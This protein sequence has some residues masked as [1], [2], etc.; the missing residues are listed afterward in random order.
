MFVD[1]VVG[2]LHRARID[3]YRIERHFAH[4]F[5]DDAVVHRFCRIASPRK[6]AVSADEYHI[7]FGRIVAVLFKMLD[8]QRT[9]LFFVIAFDGFF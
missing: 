9:R 1:D 2:K 6:G 8:D 7:R 4:F 5:E 3:E